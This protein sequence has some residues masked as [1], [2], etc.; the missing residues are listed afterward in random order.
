[1]YFIK[2]LKI[3]TISSIFFNSL[4]RYSYVSILCIASCDKRAPIDKKNPEGVVVM[5]EAAAKEELEKFTLQ[6]LKD[7]IELSKIGNPDDIKRYLSESKIKAE[8]LSNELKELKK[9]R[10]ITP[11][12]Q[13]MIDSLEEIQ[14]D[15]TNRGKLIRLDKDGVFSVVPSKPKKP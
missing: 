14:K 8:Q 11:E 5:Q 2:K 10:E 15:T 12:M 4:C 3:K 7:L 9:T 13:K 1:M 6:E